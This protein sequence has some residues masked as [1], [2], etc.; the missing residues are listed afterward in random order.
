MITWDHGKTHA[1]LLWRQS[2]WSLVSILLWHFTWTDWHMRA[3]AWRLRRKHQGWRQLRHSLASC[4]TSDSVTH[5]ASM[6]AA[7]HYVSIKIAKKGSAWFFDDM[8]I[9][10]SGERPNIFEKLLVYDI[11]SSHL[12]IDLNAAPVLVIWTRKII[13]NYHIYTYK[14]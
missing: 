8:Y 7:T 4:R 12:R 3:P 13:G 11:N 2:H 5:T 14:Y 6:P 10:I 1:F 9:S